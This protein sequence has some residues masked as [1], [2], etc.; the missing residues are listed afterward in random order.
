MITWSSPAGDEAVR[1]LFTTIEGRIDAGLVVADGEGGT[2]P[3]DF[4]GF[5]RGGSRYHPL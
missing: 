5:T 4:L 3:G 2:A 1:D